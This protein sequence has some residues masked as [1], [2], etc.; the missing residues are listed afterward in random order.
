MP[1]LRRVSTK[2]SNMSVERVALAQYG[3]GRI[4]HAPILRAGRW[5]FATGI[6]A[7]AQNGL[8]HPQVFNENRPFESPPKPEREARLI[9]Q[10]LKDGLQLAGSDISNMVRLD[11][12]YPDWRAVDPYHV[13][14]KDVLAGAVPPSTSI[15][16]DGLLNRNAEMDVQAIATTCDSNLK[17]TPAR[18]SSLAPPKESGYAPCLT[19]GDLVFVAGQ[20]ARDET[21]NLSADA[22]VPTTHLWKGTR[23]RN[24]TDYLIRE[25]LIPAL[26]ASSS[27]LSLVLKAQ[28][29]LSHPEDFPVFWQSWAKAFG[30]R[31]PPTTV[32]PVRHPGFN[33]VDARME[34][35]LIAAV[36]EARPRI[37]DV[38]CA[39]EL[40]SNDML[41]ARSLDGLLFVAG[42]MPIDE[43]GLVPTARIDP[44]APFFA[45]GIR[46]QMA[47]ILDKARIIFAAAGTSLDNVV[48]VLQF[49]ADL[50]TFYDTYVEWER[51]V[52][53]AG[54]PFSAIQVN[55]SMFVP[56]AGLIVDLWGYIPG[57]D[58][59]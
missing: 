30:E 41:P 47:N 13:V 34:V 3:T 42:L 24:E 59:T 11:Q 38:E 16:V 51:V 52:G 8:L 6:R 28:V 17:I 1:G 15:L 9:F 32:V 40:L 56:G 48:R 19:A 55:D 20:L 43:N 36:E 23:I 21:G 33:V 14:R 58:Q 35:N 25:R 29:Y 57:R 50:S 37:R 39:V 10:R 4:V 46:A 22:T 26:A 45:D 2:G 31:I 53:N 5:V 49:H 18:P 27:D 12:Y 44:S 54:L 7:V